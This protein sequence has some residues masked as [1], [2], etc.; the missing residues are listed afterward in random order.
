M[1]IGDRKWSSN[2]SCCQCVLESRYWIIQYFVWSGC[3]I[4]DSGVDVIESLWWW[5]RDKLECTFTSSHVK[6]VQRI[7][8]L[9]EAV[10]YL[11]LLNE[12]LLYS[13]VFLAPGHWWLIFVYLY[14]VIND[15]F[16]YMNKKWWNQIKKIPQINVVNNSNERNKSKKYWSHIKHWIFLTRCNSQILFGAYAFSNSLND[17]QLLL[18]VRKWGKNYEDLTAVVKWRQLSG[19]VYVTTLRERRNDNQWIKL[20]AFP[21]FETRQE[22]LGIKFHW[23]LTTF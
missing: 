15:I 22:R 16:P 18:S 14:W 7:W 1:E 13:N 5:Q 10:C 12:S 19:H 3:S 20:T 6:L 21:K 8:N 23:F 17:F 11:Y 2:P 9:G 4:R